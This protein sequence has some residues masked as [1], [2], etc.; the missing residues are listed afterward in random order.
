MPVDGQVGD[1]AVLDHVVLGQLGDPADQHPEQQDERSPGPQV[2]GHGLVSDASVKLPDVVVLG[3][4]PARFRARGKRHLQFAGQAAGMCPLEE[5]AHGPA[6]GGT[7]SEPLV[8]IR[9]G[10][11]AQV[12]EPGITVKPPSVID[13]GP[14]TS[15][16]QPH[17][18][19]G[20]GPRVRS[21][22]RG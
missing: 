11:I 3:E 8:Q 14:V 17:P 16:V 5:V 12:P 9:L 22:G 2:Q 7:A 20:R 10:K 4:Q 21:L 1:L 13:H 15:P 18:Q 6:G 19:L